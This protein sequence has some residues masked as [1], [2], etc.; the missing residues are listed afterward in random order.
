MA[1]SL[2]PRLGLDAAETE[3]VVWLIQEHLTMSTMAQSRDLG[4]PKTIRAFADVVQSPERLKLLLLLTVADIRAV[5]PGVWNGWKGQL[6]RTLYH[7]AEPLV[8]GGVTQAGTKQRV[9]AAEDAF[10][11]RRA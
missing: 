5:G 9:A 11:D 4:D 2:C 3:T 8:S 7:E 10:R 6:L 1:R